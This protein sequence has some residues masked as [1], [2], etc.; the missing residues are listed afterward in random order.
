[1]RPDDI[2]WNIDAMSTL[3][4]RLIA[5][6]DSLDT[7]DFATIGGSMPEFGDFDHS[8]MLH[9]HHEKA[10]TVMLETVKA[11]IECIDTFYTN[12]ES[13]QTAFDDVDHL[14]RAVFTQYATAVDNL[15]EQSYLPGLED[16]RDR[17]REHASV[18]GGEPGA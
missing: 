11:V 16:A 9:S 8:P 17:G 4:S 1:M 18:G 7:G 3:R 6:R 14:S 10:H 5:L 2:Q 15:T 13:A 12:L